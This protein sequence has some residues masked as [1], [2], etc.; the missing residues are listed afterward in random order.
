MNSKFYKNSH[1]YTQVN[2]NMLLFVLG[3]VCI[4]TGWSIHSHP[5]TRWY[6]QSQTF[7]TFLTYLYVYFSMAE[8][9]SQSKFACIQ[10]ANH[11][12]WRVATRG[13]RGYFFKF[14]VFGFSTR[15]KNLTQSDLRFCENEASK[16]FKINEKGVQLDRKLR[17]NWYKML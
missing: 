5:H 17:E 1:N 3:S 6:S 2:C 9:V 15:E 4:V 16:R 11:A 8:Y 7:H 13:R 10:H 12:Q 14:S